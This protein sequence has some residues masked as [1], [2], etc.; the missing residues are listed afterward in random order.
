MGRRPRLHRRTLAAAAAIVLAACSACG[1]RRPH[2][3]VAVDDAYRSPHDAYLTVPAP[4]VFA[5][6]TLHGATVD[7]GVRTTSGGGE[8][9]LF[10][11][12]SF[13]YQPAPGFGGVDTFA[14]LLTNAGGSAEPATVSI[15]IPAARWVGLPDLPVAVSR[16][17]G[18]VVAGVPYLFGGETSGGGRNGKVLTYDGAIAAWVEDADGMPTPV[19][20]ACATVL[21]ARV[22]VLGGS[23]ATTPATVGL[24][25]FDTPSGAWS[26]VASDPLPEARAAASCASHDGRVYLFGG[27]AGGAEGST[28]AWRYD[29]ADAPGTRWSTT[30]AP[31]P[32]PLSYAAAITVGDRIFVVGGMAGLGHDSARVFAY[33]PDSNAWT[34]YPD[35]QQAR[36]GPGAWVSGPYLY[37]GGGGWPTVLTSVERY[38]TRLGTA[39]TWTDADALGTRRRTFAYATDTELGSFFAL[40]GWNGQY[41]ASAEEGFLRAL[42]P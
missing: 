6:D 21:G 27:D 3:P 38:D 23:G 14:Y 2:P 20:N 4:G 41:L 30:L 18:A 7:A 39:G 10:A 17:A 28:T 16:P 22:Y 26:V 33:E 42:I 9:T 25:A 12:G 31:L 32:T 35:L 11:N 1:P 34:A 13:Q 5:N 40:G 29:P 15:E 8:A 36:S 37:V 19:S 24:Q